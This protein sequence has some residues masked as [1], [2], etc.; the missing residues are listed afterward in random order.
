MRR[1]SRKMTQSRRHQANAQL[2]ST[3][4]AEYTVVP[5]W[6]PCE[7]EFCARAPAQRRSAIGASH[8]AAT[9]QRVRATGTVPGSYTV[10]E[11][12]TSGNR[13]NA[14]VKI[15]RSAQTRCHGHARAPGDFTSGSHDG[16]RLME[17][18][19][20]ASCRM[21]RGRGPGPPGA[22]W[23]R[24]S[25]GSSQSAWCGTLWAQ[26]VCRAHVT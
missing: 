11:P 9:V 8:R 2:R 23:Q 6:R 16:R 22:D 5:H 17:Q 15:E 14:T 24:T 21:K 3:Q 19:R 20:R 26:P 25:G 13:G 7:S 10:T 12:S 4:P 18:R 1:S